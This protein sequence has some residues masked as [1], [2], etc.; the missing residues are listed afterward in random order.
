MG[1]YFLYAVPGFPYLFFFSFCLLFKVQGVA[2]NPLFWIGV[3]VFLFSW[4][5]GLSLFLLLCLA[6]RTLPSFQWLV[7]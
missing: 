6:A 1:S 4:K 3:I 5:G 2:T 7:G